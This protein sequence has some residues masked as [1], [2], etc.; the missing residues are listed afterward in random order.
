M[1]NSAIGISEHGIQ[2]PLMIYFIIQLF[3]I[4]NVYFKIWKKI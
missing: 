3:Y 4:V 1:A 2:N